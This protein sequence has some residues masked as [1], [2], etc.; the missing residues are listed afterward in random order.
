MSFNGV[1]AGNTVVLVNTGGK[2]VI[3]GIKPDPIPGG[4]RAVPQWQDTGSQIVRAWTLQP[5]Q[6]S[7]SDAAVKLAQL[8]AA[9]LDD[10]DA[11]KVPALFPQWSGDGK[12]YKAGDR[13]VYQGVL[14][15]V[16]QDHTSQGG[17]A[18]SSAASLF[19]KVLPGQA[20]NETDVSGKPGEWTQPDSTNP[21]HKGDRVTYKGKVYESTADGNVWAPDA[22]NAPWKQVK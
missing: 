13:I 2:P 1:L 11:L 8:Q 14:Y 17:W 9:K 20:G 5:V 7:A 22:T 3:D 6:G 21:Y 12:A 15:K 10:Q 18:P 16:L 19:A 4:Y